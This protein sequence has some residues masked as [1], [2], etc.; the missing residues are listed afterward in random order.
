MTRLWVEKY[1]SSSSSYKAAIYI[2]LFRSRFYGC[3]YQLL[4]ERLIFICIYVVDSIRFT[5]LQ[6]FRESC[7]I[8]MFG[9]IG[10]IMC[11]NTNEFL[12]T[13]HSSSL[14]N[15]STHAGRHARRPE[16]VDIMNGPFFSLVIPIYSLGPKRNQERKE[17]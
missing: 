12:V 17:L 9:T 8:M 15:Q 2:K 11:I 3:V 13:L 16:G 14:L 1:M 6:L 10:I 5:P 4:A 7:F